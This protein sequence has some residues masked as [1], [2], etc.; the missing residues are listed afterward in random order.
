MEYRTDAPA[1]SVDSLD[2][3]A[4]GVVVVAGDGSVLA[5]NRAFCGLL[6]L[7]V[8]DVVGR[9]AFEPP[10]RFESSTR[11]LLDPAETSLVMALAGD[12]SPEQL[13]L[14]HG[15]STPRWVKVRV[16]GEASR[17]GG[18]MMAVEDQ[19]ELFSAQQHLHLAVQ[20]D[21]LT[22]LCTR[23]HII[24]V[25]EA[26][27]ARAEDTGD[28]VGVLQVDLDGF[29]AIN[30]AFGPEVGDA[31][32]VEVADRLRRHC[33]DLAAV[34]RVGVD[35][36][37]VVSSADSS[38]LA[39]DTTIRH[40]ADGLRS[41]ITEPV[42]HDGLE[43]HLTASLGAARGPD[44]ASSATAL[45]AAADRAVRAS[46]QIGRNQFQFHDSTIDIRNHDRLKLDR[47]LRQAT[48]RRELEVHYQ[49]I[50]ELCT[51]RPAGAEAL[52]RWHHDQHGPI[53]PSEFIPTAE[54]TGSISAISEF[55]LGTVADDLA[56]WDSLGV[57]T[58]DMRVSVNISAAEFNRPDFVS[59]FERVL[60]STGTD[61]SRLELEITESLLVDDLGA[62]ARRLHQ[63]EDLG[64]RT[65]IDDFGTGYSS[66][67]YLHELPLHTLK[68][69]RS[70]L[71]ELTGV[72]DDRRSGA[73]TRTIIS[74]ARNL[75]VTAVAEG[76]ENN[77]QLSFLNE[78][79]CQRAQGYLFAPALPAEP[80]AR[81]M[82]AQFS[83]TAA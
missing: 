35:E 1:I 22:S 62:A 33:A 51:G 80:F 61:P 69:D 17:P 73:I 29:R 8:D 37:L 78:S 2:L 26:A 48:A 20:S 32:L 38:G 60:H 46:R 19:S 24:K 67:S 45:I 49:P 64:L 58:P 25:L 54:T 5:A 10:W 55:V 39:F 50:V 12:S 28:R 42:H 71:G 13:L 68:I 4:E 82:Q 41:A 75:G 34:G 83:P 59:R 56:R 63:L 11:G 66:L 65:A 44:D 79:G 53:P 14:M 21:P 31:V 7:S 3:L 30:D 74:L 27:L 15:S 23:E 77:H 52:V 81:F 16:A 70:F 36:F 47:D 43:L 76:V 18:V 40:L 72:D 6:G 9:S 57:T